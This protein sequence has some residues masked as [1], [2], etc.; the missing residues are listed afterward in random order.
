MRDVLKSWT[1]LLAEGDTAAILGVFS[2]WPNA[3]KDGS[4]AGADEAIIVPIVGKLIKLG[5]VTTPIRLFSRCG[6]IHAIFT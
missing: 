4:A 5:R 3:R 6:V 1:P 2:D